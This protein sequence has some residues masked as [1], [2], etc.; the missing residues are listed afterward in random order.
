MTPLT[1]DAT[2]K[3]ECA[4]Q[5]LGTEPM[6]GAF[7]LFDANSD[8]YWRLNQ[9]G[10]SWIDPGESEL[11]YDLHYLNLP[12]NYPGGIID[13]MLVFYGRIGDTYAVVGK[14]KKLVFAGYESY[15]NGR[16]IY[17]ATLEEKN[18]KT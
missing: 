11:L 12:K 8:A 16:F 14:K 2:G 1:S 18:K 9:L 10:H 3:K 17:S 15:D 6:Y 7:E 4:I 5:N 13:A